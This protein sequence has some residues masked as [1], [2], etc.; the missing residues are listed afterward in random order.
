M[1]NGTMDWISSY[2]NKAKM[3]FAHDMCLIVSNIVCESDL[4]LL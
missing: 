1:Q 2:D 3:V 4:P